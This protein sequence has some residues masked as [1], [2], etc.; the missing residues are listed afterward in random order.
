MSDAEP[1]IDERTTELINLKSELAD[2]FHSIA[3]NSN[4]IYNHHLELLAQIR[5]KKL[6]SLEQ[7]RN[8]ETSSAE[9]Q[10]DSQY[11]SIDSDV[12]EG[13][14]AMDARLMDFLAFKLKLLRER[15]PDAATYFDSQNY[16]S[17][18][19]SRR[20][21]G[22]P[23]ASFP[24]IDIRE[25]EEPLIPAKDRQED[26]ALMSKIERD[27][28]QAALVHGLGTG[29]AAVLR[30]GQMPPIPGRIGGFE[31]DHVEFVT[32]S[33]RVFNVKWIALQLGHSVI[34]PQ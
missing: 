26:L 1:E 33:D 12:E 19:Q 4:E 15:F 17:P 2:E 23:G 6:A 30:M 7:W 16:Q 10:H 34:E 5:E 29:E 25:S 14:R 9:R 32:E 22:A 3:Q 31:D 21:A 20:P 28:N 11:S 27:P 13:I 24:D 8:N 18:V